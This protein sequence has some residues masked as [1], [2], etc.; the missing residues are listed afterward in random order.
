M[1]PDAI[2]IGRPTRWGNPYSV[3]AFGRDEAIRRFRLLFE[4]HEKGA[5]TE[6]PVPEVGELRNKNLVCWCPLDKAC[7]GDVLLEIANR[8]E[9][10]HGGS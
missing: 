2:Y 5:A 10:A 9:P 7:H 6:F 8:R 4:L 1:P 3:E